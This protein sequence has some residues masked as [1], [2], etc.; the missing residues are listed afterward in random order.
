MKLYY[1]GIDFHKHY[2]TVCVMDADATVVLEA[3]VKPNSRDGFEALLGQLDAPVK[4]V[5]ESG[6][7]WGWLFD[8]LESLEKVEDVVLANAHRVRIIAEAQ[9]KTDNIDA[10]KLAKLMRADLNP[11]IHIPSA[12][13]RE[14][15]RHL[16]RNQTGA[17]WSF[18]V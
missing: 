15:R 13:I 8:V 4:A 1:A 14:R 2:S 12:E 6:L 5:Y 16:L 10:R 18:P 3:T 7:N 17:G 9:I 11:S